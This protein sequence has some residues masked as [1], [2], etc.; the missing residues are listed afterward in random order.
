MDLFT[1][2]LA[3]I[4]FDNLFFAPSA[5]WATIA[6]FFFLGYT[7][8]YSRGFLKI[9]RKDF[10]LFGIIFVILFFQP[11]LLILNGFNLDAFIDS[12]GTITLGLGFYC[13]LIIRYVFL[14]KDIKYDAVLLY[15]TYF[16]SFLFGLMRHFFRNIEDFESF[17]VFLEKRSY[18]RLSYTFTEPSF[19]TMH[20]IGV[21]LLFSY[22]VKDEKIAN[23]MI[24]LSILFCLGS[25]GFSSSSRCTIDVAVLLALFIFRGIF[26]QSAHFLRNTLFIG[27]GATIGA[28]LI[29]SSTR[30]RGILE[31]GINFDASGASRFFR[32]NAAFHGF[33]KEPFQTL[34]GYG[35]GN[36]IIPLR[37]GFEKA[38]SMY[39]NAYMNEVNQLKD[40]TEID[41]LFCFPV[42]LVSD[43]G[44]FLTV[45]V[46][47]Y[48]LYSARKK[49][50]DFF[51]L[52]MS[53]WLYMQF[54]SYAFYTIWILLFIIKWYD[55][56]KL[57][58]SYFDRM[59]RLMKI[60]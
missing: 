48:I 38:L 17:F 15:K 37:N 7:F 11:F 24:K 26:L 21:L 43:F 10:I 32:I 1:I 19:V 33:L 45:L 13:S 27:T 18:E 59:S 44:L 22:L 41:S 57:G 55:K 46:L 40:A 56:D 58:L 20:A 3:L 54:D 31:N 39:D 9:L 60:R 42:K 12:L 29:N 51:V 8:V 30:V 50:I 34:I 53:L 6:P 14:E 49:K 16:C 23:K 35:M 5:G 2:G 47:F 52:A 4:P 36:L 25:L 28:Y